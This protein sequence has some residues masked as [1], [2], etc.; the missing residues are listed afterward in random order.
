MLGEYQ[1]EE[2]VTTHRPREMGGINGCPK[3]VTHT[4]VGKSRTRRVE[5]EISQCS[6]SQ[7]LEKISRIGT[8]MQK[9]CKSLPFVINWCLWQHVQNNKV[10]STGLPRPRADLTEFSRSLLSYGRGMKGKIICSKHSTAYRVGFYFLHLVAV[11]SKAP[12]CILYSEYS[13]WLPSSVEISDFQKLVSL[14]RMNAGSSPSPTLPKTGSIT[15][16]LDEIEAAQFL[17]GT[18]ARV[19]ARCF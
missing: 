6:R 8:Q 14:I 5:T 17:H 19:Q 2:T 13:E 4:T 10:K 3:L 7:V 18:L 15:L 16:S 12:G 9:T 11:M 1:K